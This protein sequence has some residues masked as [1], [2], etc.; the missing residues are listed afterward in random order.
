MNVAWLSLEGPFRDSS[1]EGFIQDTLF[2]GCQ[3]K[4]IPCSGRASVLHCSSS[5][6]SNC[7]CCCCCASSSSSSSLETTGVGSNWGPSGPA[8]VAKDNTPA[9][10]LLFSGDAEVHALADYLLEV[11][12][13]RGIQQ[14]GVAI[15]C[16]C[17]MPVWNGCV[18]CNMR[19]LLACVEWG[20]TD[21]FRSLMFLGEVPGNQ[22]CAESDV[23]LPVLLAPGCTG[24]S[25][26][27][28]VKGCA[29]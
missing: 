25:Q 27:C 1:S 10:M 17:A 15:V 14:R 9:S 16:D 26:Q 4:S 11:Q 6:V 22:G 8:V 20:S 21:M 7:R 5:G 29:D 24:C 13:Y 12:G 2:S 18:G 28:V 3:A 19:L 23:D